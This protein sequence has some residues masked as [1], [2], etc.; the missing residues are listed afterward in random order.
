MANH[1]QTFTCA[2]CGQPITG[3]R[4]ELDDMAHAPSA[5]M[6]GGLPGAVGASEVPVVHGDVDGRGRIVPNSGC[7]ARARRG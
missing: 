7:A 4:A 3:A 1:K 5:P 2:G 6:L